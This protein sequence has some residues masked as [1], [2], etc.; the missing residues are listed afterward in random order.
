YVNANRKAIEL[1]IEASKLEYCDWGEQFS[2]DDPNYSTLD[3]ILY[4]AELLLADI[5]IRLD[6]EEPQKLVQRCIDVYDITSHIDAKSSIGFVIKIVLEDKA[7]D[8]LALI[9]SKESVNIDTLELLKHK[10]LEHQKSRT[11]FIDSFDHETARIAAELEK[12]TKAKAKSDMTFQ[13]LFR[14]NEELRLCF[15]WQ[16]AQVKDFNKENWGLVCP[17]NNY[18]YIQHSKAIRQAIQKP[19]Q[20][21]YPEIVRLEEKALNDSHTKD[22]TTGKSTIHYDALSTSSMSSVK[23]VY[24][25]SIRSDTHFNALLCA[26]DVYIIKAKTGKLPDALP[27]N[28]AKDIFSGEDFVYE[29]TV[30]GFVLRC[31]GKDVRKDKVH[32]WE[33]KVK[34]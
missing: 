5:R 4:L 30:D 25:Y 2:L 7:S 32:Q 10:L 21:A 29:R 27:A 33:F 6:S 34:D 17:K 3:G 1:T 20:K 19:Y 15:Y 22:E 8:A 28:R 11:P 23:G 14:D 13:D 9:L 16:L 26:V 18:Y 31:R 12:A 24:S